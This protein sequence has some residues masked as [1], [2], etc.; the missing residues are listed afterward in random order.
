MANLS[1]KFIVA[2][3][4]DLSATGLLAF[5][6]IDASIWSTVTLGVSGMYLTANVAQANLLK[7]SV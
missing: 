6:L 7:A 4:A 1:R 3:V 2:L 5:G